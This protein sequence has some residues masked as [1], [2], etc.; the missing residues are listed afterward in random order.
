MT[1]R[2]FIRWPGNR[3]PY[4]AVL[5]KGFLIS[6][7]LCLIG[8]IIYDRH[9]VTVVSLF[10]Q[11]LLLVAVWYLWRQSVASENVGA[12]RIAVF[13]VLIPV[14][15]C[16]TL[17]VA[18]LG[19]KANSLAI[20]GVIPIS[21]AGAYYVSAQTFLRAGILDLAAQRRPLNIILTSLWL[22]LSGDNFKALLLIQA[23]GFS[24]AAFLATAVMGV[25]RG[26]RAGLLMSAFLLVFAEPFLPT[27]MSETNG[28]IC[29]SLALTG[30]IFALHRGSFFSFCVGAFFLAM[31]FAIRPSALLVLPCVL[32]AGAMIFGTSRTRR[33]AVVVCLTIVI[34]LPSAISGLLDRTMSR[35][36][37][38]FNANLSYVVY[39]L[40]AGGMGWE[41]YQRDNPGKLDGVPEAARSHVILEASWR[42][43]EERPGDLVRGLVK[44]QVFGPSQTFAQIVRLAFLGAVGDPLKI[45]PAAAI[46]LISFLFAAVLW[47][48]R[49]SRANDALGEGKFRLF[50]GVI[51]LGYLVSIPFFYKDG[52]LRIHA[53]MLPI[54]S[55]GLVWLLLPASATN[56]TSLSNGVATRLFAGA[57]VFGFVLLGLLGF[58]CLHPRSGS[59][60]P[61][62]VEHGAVDGK[63][64]FRF[65]PG[66]P[67][68]D[69]GKFERPDP[70]ERPHWFSGA[71]PDD[72]YRSE[73][74]REIAG[75]GKLYFGFDA[76]A[77]DWKIVHTGQPVEL[78]NEIEVGPRSHSNR[79][80][81]IYR[82]YYQA[83]TVQV[84]RAQ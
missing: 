15:S 75:Q 21:D 64:L 82:D 18:W 56:C 40:V 13:A 52:G 63:M 11:W 41:Q 8:Q 71:I 44:G 28:L 2:D 26:F 69:L 14:L 43:F 70:G 27:V 23:L 55:Y 78:I 48:Q 60:E 73:G 46:A 49:A 20:C 9:P 65:Q 30:F 16:L 25:L 7:F 17:L 10:P 54:V 36:E 84:I 80:N 53:A 32:V 1:I 3:A 33:L 66:W 59:F 37:G 22:Y 58:I 62:P 19:W 4:C 57:N 38:G 51:L 74:I 61:L 5:R 42:H 39:G 77:G 81:D 35:G 34:L 24:A 6:A 50:W 45:I 72:D 83:K 31:G 29:G 67:Q 79:R 12:H 47:C 68:C 76:G